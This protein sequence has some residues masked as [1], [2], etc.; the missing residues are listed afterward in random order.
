MIW[1]FRSPQT[2]PIIVGVH[3]ILGGLQ[4][5]IPAPSACVFVPKG[6]IRH[7]LCLLVVVRGPSDTD[8]WQSIS[9]SDC[10]GVKGSCGYN[11]VVYH[12]VLLKYSVKRFG[13]SRFDKHYKRKGYL[14]LTFMT[15]KASSKHEAA[16]AMFQNADC[17]FRLNCTIWFLLYCLLYAGHCLLYFG[18]FSQQHFLSPFWCVPTIACGK[19]NFVWSSFNSDFLLSILPWRSKLWGGQL[20]VVLVIIFSIKSV[21]PFMVTTGLLATSLIKSLFAQELY[22]ALSLFGLIPTVVAPVLYNYNFYLIFTYNC[23]W[24]L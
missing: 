9:L 7:P 5:W 6:K 16:T 8:A 22:S 11:T 24:L 19:L 20:H 13:A 10:L 23:Y 3:P 21:H 1:K 4:V 2:P 14:P 15:K 18:L 17:V 12:M